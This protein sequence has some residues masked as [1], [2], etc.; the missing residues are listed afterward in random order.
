MTLPGRK[1][2]RIR[3]M[4]IGS[5]LIGAGLSVAVVCGAVIWGKRVVNRLFFGFLKFVG[6][7]GVQ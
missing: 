6:Y 1:L 5:L 2:Q 4:D 3:I 7:R